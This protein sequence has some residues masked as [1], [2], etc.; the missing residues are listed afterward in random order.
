LF[1]GG[2]KSVDWRDR[3]EGLDWFPG[4]ILLPDDLPA[5]L[6]EADIVIS[7]TA[8]ACFPVERGDRLDPRWDNSPDP[9][10]QVLDWVFQIVRPSQW[11]FGH[12]HKYRTGEFEGCKWTALGAVQAGGRWWVALPLVK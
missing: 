1:V 6:P 12:F 4:E 5:H 10:R 3:V 9:S 8:P 2:A 11:Y 7:H